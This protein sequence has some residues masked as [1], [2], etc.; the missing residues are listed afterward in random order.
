MQVKVDDEIELLELFDAFS[1]YY[2]FR[3]DALLL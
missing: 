2:S 1:S 3:C